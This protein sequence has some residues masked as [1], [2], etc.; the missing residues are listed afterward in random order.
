MA[1]SPKP[2]LT[3]MTAINR[4]QQIASEATAH[5]QDLT[6]C[7]SYATEAITHQWQLLTKAAATVGG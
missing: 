3:F 7:N 1:P 4:I 5:T 6:R 2:L